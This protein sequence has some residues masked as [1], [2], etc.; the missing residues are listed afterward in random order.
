MTLQHLKPICYSVSSLLLSQW[1]SF[2]SSL[3]PFGI[4]HP[5]Q[6]S[7]M[8]RLTNP[9]LKTPLI[10]SLRLN[11]RIQTSFSW[12]KSESLT[13]VYLNSLFATI[14]FSP[15]ALTLLYPQI[16]CSFIPFYLCQ[17]YSSTSRTPLLGLVSDIGEQHRFVVLN[18][19]S[20]YVAV[21]PHKLFL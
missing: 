18:E 12:T 3:P 17:C 16:P 11:D 14:S 9:T 5:A 21:L 6:W 1:S 4:V 10:S 7:R 13:P 20:T 8:I 15:D 2:S 19:A